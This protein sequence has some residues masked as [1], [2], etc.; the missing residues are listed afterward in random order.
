V[1]VR[2]VATAHLGV[3]TRTSLAIVIDGIDMAAEMFHYF[4]LQTDYFRLLFCKQSDNHQTICYQGEQ[5]ENGLR[6]NRAIA[7]FFNSRSFKKKC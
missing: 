2:G 5:L 3:N 4:R 1:G 7:D 6:R